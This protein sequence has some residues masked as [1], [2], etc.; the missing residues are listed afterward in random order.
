[1]WPHQ[2]SIDGEDHPPASHALIHPGVPL[3]IL[4]KRASCWLMAW[5][6]RVSTRALRSSPVWNTCDYLFQMQD[7]TLALNDLQLVPLCPA[8]QSI[9][10]S[11]NSSTAF[12]WAIYSSQIHI[13]SKLA[14]GG[15]ILSSKLLMNIWT[16]SDPAPTPGEHCYLQAPVRYLKLFT[17]S[18]KL[19][20][21]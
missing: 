9:H 2:G 1:M 15:S 14:K 3:A 10:F 19:C 7:S 8:H 21:K 11:P 20:V 4:A 18:N 13:S 12:Q 17:N 6:I 16:R 5:W